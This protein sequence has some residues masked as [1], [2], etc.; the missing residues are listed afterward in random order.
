MAY[1]DDTDTS[2]CCESESMSGSDES[3]TVD[4]PNLQRI[5][6]VLEQLQQALVQMHSKNLNPFNTTPLIA[7]L[8]KI[9]SLSVTQ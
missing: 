3:S 9:Q 1:N 2:I 6:G 4:E 8:N 7:L 5:L